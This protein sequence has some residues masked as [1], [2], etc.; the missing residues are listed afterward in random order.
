MNSAALEFYRGKRIF[1][2]GHTGFKGSWLTRWLLNLG[3]AR[4]TGYSRDIPTRPSLFEALNLGAEIDH[5]IGDVQNL[6]GVQR[7]M[8]EAR[9]DVILH[10]AAQPLVRLSYDIPVET[11]ATNVMGTI[12]T[13]EA[14][15]KLEGD[16]A[17][18]NVTSDK[19]YAPSIQPRDY[20]E[21]DPMGGHDPYSASKGCAEL[22]FGAYSKSFLAGSPIRAASARAGNVIGGGDWAS[23]RL[24]PD[25]IRAWERKE[26]VILRNPDAV[27]PWQHVLEPL[28]GYLALGFKLARGDIG[29]EG[30]GFNFGPAG[31]ATTS[32]MPVGQVV[33]HLARQ[34]PGAKIEI[35]RTDGKPEAKFLSLD[36]SKALAILPWQPVYSTE[37]AIQKTGEWY[38]TF[39]QS[40]STIRDLTDRQI[41]EYSIQ[42]KTR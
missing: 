32:G 35:Q 16:V 7:A 22:I 42:N 10:L 21:T 39:R 4:I 24:I 6:E 36:C 20:L 11:F 8:R 23:D 40:P 41:S 27:R 13:L 26:S 37:E 34:W 15:R 19:C 2:T 30:E 9:P 18:V 28:A 25:C 38:Q 33:E 31:D 3:A 12:H 5:R 29:I 14:A 17:F 1:I